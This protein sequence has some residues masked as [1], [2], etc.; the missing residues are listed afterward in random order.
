LAIVNPVAAGGRTAGLWRRLEPTL[1]QHFSTL[2]VSPTTAPGDAEVFARRWAIDH[3]GG[4]IIVLGGDGTVHE[5][6]NGLIDGPGGSPLGVIPGG[7][8]NDFVRNAGLP[9]DPDAAMNRLRGGAS[10]RVDLGQLR[11]RG[12]DGRDHR[13]VFLNSAS[14]GV[15]P[16]ANRLAHSIRRVLPGRICYTLGGILALLLEGQGR[17]RISAGSALTYDGRALN[18]T[19]ANGACFGGG[20]RISPQSSLTDGLMEQVI[21]GPIGGVRALLALSRLYAGTHVT[22]RGVSV[23]PTR[24]SIRISHADGPMLLEADGHDWTTHGDLLVDLLPG[25]LQLLS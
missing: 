8:G 23:T 14:V 2:S 1:R 18:V 22:M 16:R 21:I 12:A 25:A 7:T 6:V 17:Y 24:D 10:R 13:R 3:P 20:M 15:S 19:I 4:P 5:V 9:L 11:F